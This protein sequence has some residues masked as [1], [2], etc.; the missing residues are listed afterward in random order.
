VHD[1]AAKALAFA[2][3]LGGT[4]TVLIITR[5]RSDRVLS[6]IAVSILAVMSIFGMRPLLMAKSRDYSLYGLSAARGFSFAVTVGAAG[7]LALILGY[8]CGLALFRSQSLATAPGANACRD[9]PPPSILATAWMAASLTV[10]WLALMALAGGGLGFLATLYEGRSEQVERALAGVPVLVGSLPLAGAISLSYVRLMR[11]KVALLQ[12]SEKIAYWLGVASTIVPPLALGTRRYL[13]PAVIVAAVAASY[14]RGS[15][16]VSIGSVILAFLTF[17][18]LAV[19]PYTRGAGARTL[20]A[21]PIKAMTEYFKAHDLSSIVYNVFVSFDTEMFNYVAYVGPRLGTGIPYGSGRGTI[22]ELVVAPL[23]ARFG[24]EPWSDTLLTRVF[25][26]SCAEIV[27][28][29]ASLPGSLLFDGGLLFV[30]G[31]MLLWGVAC[32]YLHG[33]WQAGPAIRVVPRLAIVAFTIVIVRGNPVSS[34]IIA[35]YSIG[36][37]LLGLRI[38]AIASRASTS[39]ASS[40]DRSSASVRMSI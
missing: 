40:T 25:G 10:L 2:M 38:V 23:P 16:R 3:V 8:F 4:L 35:M 9:E 26:G 22:G 33:S 27:C 24:I 31:G 5:L 18:L 28:P 36:F 30:V 7:M 29:V 39:A 20:G 37:A 1:E 17:V 32:A 6:P 19:I 11:E 15:R 13:I 12:R 21:G 34:V 14:S